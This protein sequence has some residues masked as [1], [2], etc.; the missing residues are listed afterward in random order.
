M[1]QQSKNVTQSAYSPTS[2]KSV[3][4]VMQIVVGLLLVAASA[5]GLSLLQ[6]MATSIP[7]FM[8]A[9]L[10]IHGSKNLI[11]CRVGS[12]FG[13]QQQHTGSMPG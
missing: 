3:F 8:G 1:S 5:Y 2:C 6:H 4:N 9:A 10:F 11:S 13:N 12:L 7:A